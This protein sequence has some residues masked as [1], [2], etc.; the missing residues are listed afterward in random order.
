MPNP[1]PKFARWQM[2]LQKY[3]F[4]II[5]VYKAGKTNRNADA[6]SKICVNNTN[7]IYFDSEINEDMIREEQENNPVLQELK[8]A[9]DGENNTVKRN[10]KLATLLKKE[11][12]INENGI[13][14]RLSN[15]DTTQIV[16]PPSLHES[17]FELLHEQP[18]A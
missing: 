18:C 1:S 15:E 9:M 3:D 5:H 17:V 11:L 2:S 14:Y 13:I 4:D 6:L 10:S 7:I 8:K 12:Y 16:L